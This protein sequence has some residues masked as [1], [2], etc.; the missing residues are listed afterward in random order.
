MAHAKWELQEYQP[1]EHMYAKDKVQF[2]A[3]VCAAIGT[4]IRETFRSG[5]PQRAMY[6]QP[7]N[8]IS[9]LRENFKSSCDAAHRWLEVE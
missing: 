1:V 5:Y 8:I 2:M 7:A 6:E 4:S 3:A 9:Q